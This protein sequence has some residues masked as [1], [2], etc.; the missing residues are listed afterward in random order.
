MMES[1]ASPDPTQAQ[2]Q[3][4]KV[5]SIAMMKFNSDVHRP[6]NLTPQNAEPSM[7]W[8]VRGITID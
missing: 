4:M 6:V 3:F 8:T 1:L 7:N 5:I 2:D